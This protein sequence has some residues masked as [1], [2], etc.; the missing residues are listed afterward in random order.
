MPLKRLLARL[1]GFPRAD[2]GTIAIQFAL[3]LPALAL[4]VAG[5]TDL[6][7]VHAA[8]QRLEDISDAAALAGA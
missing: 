8:K 2:R 6:V 5:A 1:F 7:A 4:G 3:A